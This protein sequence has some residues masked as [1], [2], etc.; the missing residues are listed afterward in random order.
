MHNHGKGLRRKGV[1]VLLG[2]M[3]LEFVSGQNHPD[4]GSESP[5][6]ETEDY[7][8]SESPWH[9]PASVEE[10]RMPVKLPRRL[11]Q[12][13]GCCPCSPGFLLQFAQL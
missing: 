3:V 2:L 10:A 12:V 5:T 8:P 11:S 9:H 4:H 6:R 7:S 13:V 1:H